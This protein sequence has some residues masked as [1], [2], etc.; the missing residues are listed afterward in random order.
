MNG[1]KT[2]LSTLETVSLVA[3]I[4]C[5][6]VGPMYFG[7]AIPEHVKE[8]RAPIDR[9]RVLQPSITGQVP[10]LLRLAVKLHKHHYC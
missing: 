2:W 7:R 6:A 1:P 8:P 9:S 4:P 10:Q 3:R 5:K